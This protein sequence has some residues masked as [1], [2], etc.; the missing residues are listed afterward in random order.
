M[1]HHV[2]HK[3]QRS[4][5]ELPVGFHY[6]R[7]LERRL[8]VQDTIHSVHFYF[9]PH[10]SYAAVIILGTGFCILLKHFTVCIYLYIFVYSLQV[11]FHCFLKP[12][13]S[14]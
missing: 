3:E 1:F 7:L 6:V 9:T 5:K 13:L 12:W 8:T 2:E 4:H 14:V 10:L 11:I